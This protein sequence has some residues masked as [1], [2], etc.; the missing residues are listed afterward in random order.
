[1]NKFNTFV[2]CILILA[3]GLLKSQD[4]P[5]F[6][7]G[8]YIGLGLNA[9]SADFNKLKEIPN[10][11]PKFESGSGSG[12]SFGLFFEIPASDKIGVIL[13]AG[14]ADLSGKFNPTQVI[15][16]TE[17]RK[18]VP[19][20]DNDG[21]SDVISQFNLES[22]LSAITIDP[23]ISW[24]FARSITLDIGLRAGFLMNSTFS[25]EEVLISPD[26]VVFKENEQRVRNKVENEAIEPLS[27]FQLS[28]MIGASYKLP[29]GEFSDLSLDLKYLFPFTSLIDKDWKISI[30][31]AGLSL[32]LPY[33]KSKEIR[34]YKEINIKRDTIITNTIAVKTPEVNLISRDSIINIE[35]T[36]TTR[37]EIITYIEKYEL[38]MPKTANLS[39]E[40]K[41]TGITKDGK[42][43]ENPT[44]IIEE[45]ETEEGFPIL[46]HVFFPDG[47]SDLSK[48]SMNLM[49]KEQT[50][51][52]T[53]NGLEWETLNIYKDMLNVIA[54]RMKMNPK[55]KIAITGTNNN[56]TATE[57]GNLKLS[58]ERAIAV[59]KYLSETWEINPNRI[60]IAKR[61]LPQNPANNQRE[62]GWVEN[63]RAEINSNDIEIMKP[64]YLKEIAV[65]SNPPVIELLPI[66]KSEAGIKS[67]EINVL[68]KDSKLRNYSGNQIPE[69]LYWRIEDEPMPKVEAPIIIKLQATDK[70]S[71][72][73]DV[74]KNLKLEQLTIKK[75]RYEL[76]DDKRVERFSLIVFDF[77]KADLKQIHLNI[78]NDIKSRIKPNSK[79]T[80]MGYADRSGEADYNKELAAKRTSEVQKILKVAPENLTIKNIGSDELIY[81]NS[82]PQGRSYCRTVKIYVETPVTE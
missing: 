3:V 72:N 71:S 58:E 22:N 55:S 1:M 9:H 68:Q 8:P 33:M 46:P 32:K 47:S 52:F 62:D 17:I 54:Y 77:N 36:E 5:V 28:G 19:P 70:T 43:Q 59:K 7:F 79:V 57:K 53:E 35:K 42:R 38:K 78:L 34:T 81:D 76:K 26:F 15:G 45:T 39:A 82:S 64:V 29:V 37:T 65:S 66:I 27:S 44:I 30:L 74:D 51:K 67:W 48:S 13:R 49:S 75:K 10:C 61:N 24:Y 40:I 56:T 12:L 41:V 69:A 60:E 18:S 25:Q 16:N 2:F 63:S 11:C 4:K 80:I 21:I 14:Y 6:Y 20:Y 31:Y 73:I 23:Y 50:K